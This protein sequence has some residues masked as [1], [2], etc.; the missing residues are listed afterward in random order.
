MK[1]NRPD[2]V[3]VFPPAY[4]SLGAFRSHLGV[5]YLR[6]A[7]ARDG[8]VT[9]QYHN[10]N[11]GPVDAV[12]AEILALKPQIV[13]FT[14]Y[15]TNFPTALAL[16][17]SIKR[18]RPGVRVVLGG[19]TAT[20]C[21]KQILERHQVID[22]CLLGEA[23]ETGARIFAKLLEGGSF[24]TL[25]P[26][27]A[28]RREGLVFSTGL[29]P[30]VGSKGG[31][32]QSALDTTPSPYL[33]GILT[34][35]RAGI[36]TG[37]GCTHHC[38]YCAFAALGR[39]KL[40]LHSIDRVVAELEYIAAHQKRTG[41]HY[42]VSVHDDAFTLLPA[43]AKALCQAIAE[44]KL[45][46]AL[47]GITRAD[48][49]DEELLRLMR[50]AG[51]I[52]LAFGLESSVPSVLRATGKVRPPDWPDP[53]LGP[54]RRFVEQVRTSVLAAKKQGFSVGVSI[55]LGLPTE[56]AEDGA[57]TLRFVK[58]LPIDYY[59]HNLL[60]VFPGTP[61]W[62]SHSRYGIECET[63]SQGLPNTT[64][65]A[66]D[67]ARVKPRPKCTRERD[68]RFIRLLTA[69]TLYGCEASFSR[70]K[71]AEVVVVNAPELTAP[72][73]EWLSRV[74]RIGGF[75]VQTYPP[76]RRNELDSR[77]YRDRRLLI[78]SLVPARYYV[79]ALRKRD[80][81]ADERWL[82]GC[83][84]VDLYRKLKPG[85]LSVLSSNGPA[86]LVDWVNGISTPFA[87][88]EVTEYLQQP[89]AL[90]HFLDQMDERDLGARLQ[91]MPVP[92]GVRYSG[93]WQKRRAPCRR[94]T[95]MEVDSQG[96]V[97]T[98]RHGEPIGTVGDTRDR[99]SRRL[100]GVVHEVEQRRGCAKCPNTHCPRCPFPGVK[101]QVYCRIM[102]KQPR[103]LR[104]LDLT[105]LYSRLP[106]ILES[107]A[108]RMESSESFTK[109]QG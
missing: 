57:A 6:G 1:P 15:D 9:A 58:E 56:T 86:P 67:L 48:A 75:V 42:I 73:A 108:D 64:G 53:D 26:G 68:A 82:A 10:D 104:F 43:R 5:A 62:E 44:R 20:F 60:W 105:E 76:L 72:T 61:L 38:Q 13:G 71:G 102:T 41:E 16:A 100:A 65:Y 17:R 51:F 59:T 50:K 23:E 24:D 49:V 87:L 91:Q 77:L 54:E 22:A 88:C 97:R 3:F 107:Q 4:G 70:G 95:R 89:D 12:A 79:Q 18:R 2:I 21:S 19:P 101:D 93:R 36:L 35:G 66:Y 85:I 29:P 28:V 37:R 45:S 8:I 106:I 27:V 81:I 90:E 7:L 47:M 31:V 14:V 98:C 40:R 55:I 63:N 11:P 84:A 34:D 80:R 96:M 52:S 109:P 46:L 74:L 30:L 33:S 69:D 92:P 78:D 83:L 94:L 99:L 25:Q 39:K 32:A 103:I